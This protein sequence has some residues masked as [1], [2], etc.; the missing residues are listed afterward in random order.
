MHPSSTPLFDGDPFSISNCALLIKAVT[1]S[2]SWAKLCGGSSMVA[3]SGAMQYV[4]RKCR[5]SHWAPGK[6]RSSLLASAP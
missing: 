1:R 4:H 6:M 2:G 3:T 5:A